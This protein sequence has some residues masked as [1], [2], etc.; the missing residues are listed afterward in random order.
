M[1]S[2]L[3]DVEE[4]VDGLN[5]NTVF[6]ANSFS[7]QQGVTINSDYTWAMKQG[8]LVHLMLRFTTGQYK[9]VNL[10]MIQMPEALKPARSS[11]P[12]ISETWQTATAQVQ[13]NAEGCNIWPTN[14]TK[15]STDYFLDCTYIAADY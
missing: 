10:R 6:Y 15:T 5:G 4:S 3:T 12:V 9:D 11:Y 13:L 14:S 7:A 2:N 1:N 8:K